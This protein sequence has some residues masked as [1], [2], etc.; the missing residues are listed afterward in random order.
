MS[1][2]EVVLNQACIVS[3]CFDDR[4]SQTASSDHRTVSEY[5]AFS[6]GD[7]IAWEGWVNAVVGLEFPS[8][9]VDEAT[10]TVVI[11]RD[12]HGHLAVNDG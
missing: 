3:N 12:P 9:V 6:I 7:R 5:R 8:D 11:E 1:I 4:N 2:I 10:L